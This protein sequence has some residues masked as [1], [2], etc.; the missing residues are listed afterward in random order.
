MTPLAPARRRISPLDLARG[1]FLLAAVGFG[2][3]GLRAHAPAIADALART[4]PGRVVAACVLVLA[5]LALTGSVWRRIL[6]AH[7][8]TVPPV[9]AAAIFFVGQLGKYIPGSVWSL[10]AQADMARRVGVPPRT[11]VAVGLL[12]LWV[13]VVTAVPLGAI[14][15][16]RA[17]AGIPRSG[18]VAAALIVAALALAPPVLTRLADVLAGAPEPISLD[19]ADVGG[20]VVRM[21]GVWLLYGTAALLVVPPDAL[22]QAGGTAA[23]LIPVTAAFAASY[24]LGV[25]VV[26]APA[27]LGAREATMVALLAPTL[28]LPV[29]AATTLLIRAVHTVCDFTIAGISWA[30][31][32]RAAT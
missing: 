13:H 12:F 14:A 10:G 16:A 26:L 3:W 28:G 17:V 18:V 11:T 24:V 22:S 4:S 19:W 27:G 32:R 8:H 2:W 25:V 21:S 20:L 7:G 5:G 29:A 6:A 1:L 23:Q 31:A 30:V 15:A 9:P